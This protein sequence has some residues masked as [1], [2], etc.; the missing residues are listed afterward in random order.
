MKF[1]EI[2]ARAMSSTIQGLPSAT[3]PPIRMSSGENSTMQFMMP[4]ARAS[5]ASR[6]TLAARGSFPER[7]ASKT[8]FALIERGLD[9]LIAS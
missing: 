8:S 3:P 4:A 1:G 5:H 2:S 6:D 9:P 7:A